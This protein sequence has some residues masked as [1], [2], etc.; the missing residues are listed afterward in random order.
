MRRELNRI[1]FA[2]AKKPIDIDID[3]ATLPEYNAPTLKPAPFNKILHPSRRSLLLEAIY[4]LAMISSESIEQ[5]GYTLLI[6][7]GT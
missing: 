5:I 2:I 7:I 4:F 1:L 6:T 3:C